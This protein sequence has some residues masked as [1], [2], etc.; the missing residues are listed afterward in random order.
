MELAGNVNCSTKRGESELE[1]KEE[2]EGGME[3]TNGTLPFADVD[4]FKMWHPK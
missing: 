1:G 4:L 3:L 2:E